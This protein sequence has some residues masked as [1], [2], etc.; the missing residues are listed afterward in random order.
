MLL[1]LAEWLADPIH[2]VMAFRFMR[3]FRTGLRISFETGDFADK[4]GHV[5]GKYPHLTQSCPNPVE[6]RAVSSICSEGISRPQL[7]EGK[8]S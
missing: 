2:K 7:Y 1:I 4:P 6:I 3:K 8:E 5:Q